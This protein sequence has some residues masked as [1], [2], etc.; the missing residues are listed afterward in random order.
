MK[1]IKY[2]FSSII[3]FSLLL[4]TCI[5]NFTVYASENEVDIN[6]EYLTYDVKEENGEKH[7]YAY[8]RYGDIECHLFFKDNIVFE[9]DKGNL[10]IIAYI[11]ENDPQEGIATR[12]VEP[13]WG[14]MLSTRTRVTFPNPESSAASAITAVIIGAWFPGASLAYSI[15]SAI[16]DYVMSYKQNYVDQTCYYREAAGCPQ[17][18]WYSKYEYRNKNGAV[19]KTVSINRKSFI[20]V[21]QS[22]E[23]PPACRMYGF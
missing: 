21:T 5:F 17:Y 14:I 13:S 16:A 1:I 6:D 8:N 9:E 22:P 2:L 23:N 10:K 15:A 7:V 4:C 18:R 3:G 12:A 20:G 11:E 19:F